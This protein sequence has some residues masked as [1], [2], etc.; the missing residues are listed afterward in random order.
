MRPF[1]SAKFISLSA[2]NPSTGDNEKFCLEDT[3]KKC[4]IVNPTK[5][6]FFEARSFCHNMGGLLFEPTSL[7]KFRTIYGWA[8]HVKKGNKWIG[9]TQ[10][11]SNWVLDSSSFTVNF[12]NWNSDE[13]SESDDEHCLEIHEDGTWNNENCDDSEYSICEINNSK[14]MEITFFSYRKK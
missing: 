5:M 10:E 9:L 14:N 11:D 3:E 1:Q 12:Q 4:Y 7:E 8:H 6:S 2:D 13:P